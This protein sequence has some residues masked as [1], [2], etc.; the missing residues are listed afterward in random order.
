MM[1]F[2]VMSNTLITLFLRNA[3]RTALLNEMES[4]IGS[5]FKK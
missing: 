4:K 2:G 5:S 1:V 3:F